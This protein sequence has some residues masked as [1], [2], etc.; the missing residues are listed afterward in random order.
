MAVPAE[1]GGGRG[2]R[3]VLRRFLK[4]S[5]YMILVVVAS[6][7]ATRL[8]ILPDLES[9]A[10]D[11]Q[12]RFNRPREESQVAV[13]QIT[14]S[15]YQTIFGAKSPLDPVQVHR[16]LAAVAEERP[17]VIGVDLDTSDAS[18]ADFQIPADWPTV[19]WGR[20]ALARGGG[21]LQPLGVLGG[22]R[23]QPCSGI[24]AM[25]L[26]RDG[27]LRHY[28]RAFPGQALCDPQACRPADGTAPPEGRRLC[29][30]DACPLPSFAWAV[31]QAHSAAGG[32]FT[33]ERFGALKASADEGDELA[34]S[35]A[36]ERR[37]EPAGADCAPAAAEGAGEDY[38]LSRRLQLTAS[39][40]LAN[41]AEAGRARGEGEREEYRPLKGKIVLV[42]GTYSSYARDEHRTPLGMMA[43][44]E[45]IAQVLETELE[46]GGLP[47]PNWL[48]V[49]ALLL[50]DNLLLVLIFKGFG[51]SPVRTL[52]VS[53]AA[54]LLVALFCSAAAFRTPRFWV[55][56]VP[57]L[58][59]ALILELYDHAKDYRDHLW[60]TLS[61][62]GADAPRLAVEPYAGTLGEYAHAKLR[63]IAGELAKEGRETDAPRWE[64]VRTELRPAALRVEL[65]SKFKGREESR[66]FYFYESAGGEKI[67]VEAADEADAAGEG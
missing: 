63:E 10:L 34:V 50:F 30:T 41:E 16:L 12:M 21:K 13:V 42:G 38:Q 60:R 57:V 17:S 20:V 15:D 8:G 22:R 28:R 65:R 43:G 52:A 26:D 29:E 6:A 55:Y 40:V 45:V 9:V 5:A 4:A 2:G 56:F 44:V 36:A 23:P 66:R 53:V 1:R 7:A 46:G 32:E 35:F 3:V 61:E 25:Q 27:V 54:V 64:E 18:F 31:L 39:E 19:V 51:H 49:V 14:D 59:V 48:I 37:P 24:V 67:V 11:A 58:F 33:P 62:K 47:P